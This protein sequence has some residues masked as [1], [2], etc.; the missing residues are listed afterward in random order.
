MTVEVQI[1]EKT[2]SILFKFF[3]DFGDLGFPFSVYFFDLM[4]PDLL[5]SP[6]QVFDKIDILAVM[7]IY[8]EVLVSDLLRNLE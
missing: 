1:L 8:V 5:V 2:F 7:E 3:E 6:M 4:E